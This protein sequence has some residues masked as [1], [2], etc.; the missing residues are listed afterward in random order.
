MV[1]DQVET[2]ASLVGSGQH[3][4]RAC[5]RGTCGT[6]GPHGGVVDGGGVRGERREKR[7]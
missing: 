6:Q 4:C 3:K 1:G 5:S 2:L 7:E